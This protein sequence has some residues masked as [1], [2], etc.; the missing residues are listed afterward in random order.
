M[1]ILT[2][3]LLGA[4]L[5]FLI[6]LTGVGGGALVAPVLYVGL[7]ISYQEAIALSLIYSSFTKIVGAAQRCCV[8]ERS[9][10]T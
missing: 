8:R 3:V 7:G 6:G 9:S 10:E 2:S 4:V 1:E 5:G